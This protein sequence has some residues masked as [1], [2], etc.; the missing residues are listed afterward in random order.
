MT[1]RESD[2][3]IVLRDGSAGH[4]GKGRTERCSPHRKPGPACRVGAIQANLTAGNSDKG[5]DAFCGSESC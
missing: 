2:P 3:P 5:G 1:N 4:R